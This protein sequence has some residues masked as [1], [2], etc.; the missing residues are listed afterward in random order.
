MGVLVYK[1]GSIYEGFFANGLPN[2]KGRKINHEDLEVYTGDFVD[3]L[4]H[5][6]GTVSNHDGVAATA[7]W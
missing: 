3:G 7:Q 1:D 4:K 2:G 6:D 5:G